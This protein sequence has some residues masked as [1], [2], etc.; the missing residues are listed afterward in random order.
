MA[1]STNYCIG[2]VE[3]TKLATGVTKKKLTL[4]S[5][6]SMDYEN[7]CFLIIIFFIVKMI[8][9]QGE[10]KNERK[11]K[12]PFRALNGIKGAYLVISI[13]ST[14]VSNRLLSFAKS[15]KSETFDSNTIFVLEFHLDR[16]L[17]IAIL[18]ALNFLFS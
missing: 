16:D 15:S 2:P 5:D 1:R 7:V 13:I 12:V 3:T 10:W 4:L 9:V 17:I 18:E 6:Y 11:S 14:A 8:T